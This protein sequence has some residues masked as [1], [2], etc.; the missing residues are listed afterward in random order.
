MANMAN[1]QKISFIIIIIFSILCYEGIKK[2][3]DNYQNDLQHVATN[4]KGNS[5]LKEKCYSEI[6]RIE[7]EKKGR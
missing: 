1:I 4:L 3:L 7:N 5:K 2:A 6:K